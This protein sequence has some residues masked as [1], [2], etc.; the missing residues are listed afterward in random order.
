M[1]LLK[2]STYVNL[3]YFK[4]KI[5]ADEDI[6]KQKLKIKILKSCTVPKPKK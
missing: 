6:L 5:C 2:I 1:K 3:F 4:R